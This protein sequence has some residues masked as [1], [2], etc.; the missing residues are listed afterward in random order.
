MGYL[1]LSILDLARLTL[2]RFRTLLYRSPYSWTVPGRFR[3]LDRE[4]LCAVVPV[5]RL[6]LPVCPNVPASASGRVLTFVEPK[7]FVRGGSGPRGR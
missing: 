4:T 7:P 1:T 2:L 6:R 3:A 5:D